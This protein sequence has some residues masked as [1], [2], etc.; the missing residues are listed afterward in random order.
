[1]ALVQES[2]PHFTNAFLVLLEI[3]AKSSNIFQ[4]RSKMAPDFLMSSVWELW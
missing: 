1:M 4:E 2:E 3:L